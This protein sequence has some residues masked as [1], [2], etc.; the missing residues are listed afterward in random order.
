MKTESEQSLRADIGMEL[1]IDTFSMETESEQSLRA[2]I[3]V[4]V[5]IDTFSMEPESEQSLRD[6]ITIGCCSQAYED[7]H[8]ALET[9]AIA[10]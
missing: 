6:L 5:A 8:R 3:G 1:A 4:D 10:T 2:D 9:N 7:L